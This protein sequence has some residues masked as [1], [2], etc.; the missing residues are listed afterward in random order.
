M[1]GLKLIKRF[2]VLVISPLGYFFGINV[3]KLVSQDKNISWQVSGK[4]YH[5]RNV[6]SLP[7]KLELVIWRHVDYVSKSSIIFRWILICLIF[8]CRDMQDYYMLFGIFTADTGLYSMSVFFIPCADFHPCQRGIL[9]Y[10]SFF[11]IDVHMNDA[12]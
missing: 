5:P 1:I 10:F 7:S 4:W 3:P 11:W 6:W 2:W 9:R 12:I 8:S